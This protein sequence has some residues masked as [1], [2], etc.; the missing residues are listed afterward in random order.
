M[1][2]VAPRGGTLRHGLRAILA[3]LRRRTRR[4][5]LA[6][7]ALLARV[8]LRE[9]IVLFLGFRILRDRAL[10]LVRVDVDDIAVVQLMRL[11]PRDALVRRVDEDTV[12]AGVLDE[13][14]AVQIA[15]Q[16]VPARDVRI[17]KDPVVVGQAADGAAHSLEDLAA[18]C[19]ELFCVLTGHF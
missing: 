18:G 7:A 14:L 2:F 12:G 5:N 4:R 19:A 6:R 1:I 13:V 11:G 15:D 8:Q 16:G 17:R 9:R 3:I 10:D